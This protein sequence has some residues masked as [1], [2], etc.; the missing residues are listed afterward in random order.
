MKKIESLR[1]CKTHL[2]LFLIHARLFADSAVGAAFLSPALSTC[3][4]GVEIPERFLSAVSKCSQD[5][6]ADRSTIQHEQQL[7]QKIQG[8]KVLHRRRPVYKTSIILSLSL[9]LLM[10]ESLVIR[11]RG[12]FLYGV[13][14]CLAAL[15]ANRRRVH[16][17]YMKPG[18]AA[19]QGSIKTCVNY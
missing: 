9:C 19:K 6:T 4:H 15:Q 2:T 18:V 11:R 1:A 12:E 3:Q 17:I 13:A 8:E 14:P 7:T 16:A 5:R 10:Q